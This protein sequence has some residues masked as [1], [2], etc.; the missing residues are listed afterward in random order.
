VRFRD[1]TSA[2][3]G[4]LGLASCGG[5]APSQGELGPP[6]ARAIDALAVAAPHATAPW[7]CGALDRTTVTHAAAPAGWSLAPH[8]LRQAAPGAR[9]A[10]AFV[11]D[12][13]A[14]AAAAT[15]ALRQVRTAI[16]AE[17]VDLIVSV[18]G[19]GADQAALTAALEL[20][21]DDGAVP[22][23]ALAGDLEP[24]AALDAAV[25]AVATRGKAVFDGS[26]VRAV[27]VGP[28]VLGT[29]PGHVAASRLAAG[30]DGCGH[31]DADV[32]PLR[33]LMA[34]QGE[35]L[36][37][38]SARAPAADGATSLGVG[39]LP[40]GDHALRAALLAPA[41]PG[42]RLAAVVH[43]PLG[44]AL[45]V[46]GARPADSVDTFAALGVPRLDPRP[47]ATAP[48]TEPR[49][50]ILR[51]DADGLRWTTLATRP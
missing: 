45:L 50:L 14:D 15:P 12:V 51:A 38:A 49:A 13:G 7:R 5:S 10:I 16:A 11:G 19:L 28:L 18:G 35:L 25:A 36:V 44:D 21:A 29:L 48:Q 31:R 8:V 4:A 34:A 33:S 9:A 30:A 32:G 37:L 17:Q 2:L 24:A 26:D 39:G 42:A 20:L 43:A 22:V 1:L 46:P 27:R 41:A 47:R 3:V 40:A 23:L 6:L